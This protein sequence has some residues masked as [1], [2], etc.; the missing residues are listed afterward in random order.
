[1]RFH[2]LGVQ[3]TITSK[4]Y[5][6]CAY[7]QKVLK[8]CAMMKKR[9]HE[10]IHY[11]H[12]DSVVDCSEH[13]SVVS[14]EIFKKVYTYDYHQSLFK[15]NES[16]DVYTTFNTNAIHEIGKRKRQGDFLL[17]FWGAGH[18]GICD[19]HPDMIIVEPG[20]GYA[21]GSIGL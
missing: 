19:A 4:D 13:V 8:F 15:W 9:G 16:D 21:G 20:I 2:A 5:C 11:G 14:R 3:H 1:M 18:K 12:E 6:A 10:V 7:T 17:A